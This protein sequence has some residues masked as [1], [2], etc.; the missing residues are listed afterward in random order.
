MHTFTIRHTP[1]KPLGNADALSRL[2]QPQTTESDCL[3]GDLAYLL[4]HLSAT[5]VN[6]SNIRRWTDTDPLLSQVRQFILHGEPTI[7]LGD[8][9]QAFSKHKSELSVLDGCIL[10]GSRVVVPS[11]GRKSVATRRVP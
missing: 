11:P 8:Q 10:W 5:N 2:P 7:Q 1:G 9:F 4:H 6:T 3:P